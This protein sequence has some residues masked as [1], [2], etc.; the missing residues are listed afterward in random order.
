MKMV[1]RALT[2]SCPVEP[3]DCAT[4]CGELGLGPQTAAPEPTHG[5][6]LPHGSADQG[7]YLKESGFID[8]LSLLWRRRSIVPEDNRLSCH[9]CAERP[10]RRVD[11]LSPRLFPGSCS[12]LL[13]G[14]RQDTEAFRD[15]HELRE[16][17]DARLFHHLL[18]VS[19]DR[20][21]RRAEL[22]GNLLVELSPDD[23]FQHLP[24][25]RR[26]RVDEPS[27]RIEPSVLFPGRD[28]PSNGALDCIE[29]PILAHR[30][31]QKVLSAG[32][33]RLYAR[34]NVPV[35]G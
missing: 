23:P 35:T 24:L 11:H 14:G 13:R 19:L 10:K 5:L 22:S 20:S 31:G 21:D 34:G 9:P 4:R 3:A 2:H 12:L 26:Q 17:L 25:A 33:D 29:Q 18:A 30:L 32:L 16:R 27:E 1:F 15:E 6:G 7:W 8:P 28:K